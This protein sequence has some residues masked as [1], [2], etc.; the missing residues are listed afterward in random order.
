[1]I[2]LSPAAAH[3]HVLQGSHQFLGQGS[4]AVLAGAGHGAFEAQTGLHRD[5]HLVQGVGQFQLHDLLSFLAFAVK[6]Q[7]GDDVAEDHQKQAGELDNGCAPGAAEV[8]ARYD[9]SH[10]QA[11]LG[12][13]HLAHRH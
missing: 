10:P 3:L 4:F 6:H 9:S 12:A 8:E 1:M 5:Q 13:Q 7:V 11:Q 2:G